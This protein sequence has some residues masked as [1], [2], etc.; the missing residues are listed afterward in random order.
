M[1]VRRMLYCANIRKNAYHTRVHIKFVAHMHYFH[2]E[3]IT[4]FIALVYA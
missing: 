3:K 2:H 1:K 4:W